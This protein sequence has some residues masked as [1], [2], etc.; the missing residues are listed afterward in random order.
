MMKQEI[1]K[2]IN[3]CIE[4]LNNGKDSSQEVE[5][6]DATVLAIIKKMGGLPYKG[7]GLGIG[8]FGYGDYRAS[9]EDM[10]GM[11]KDRKTITYALGWEDAILLLYDFGNYTEDGILQSAQGIIKDNIIFNHIIKHCITNLVIKNEV[12]EA[13]KFISNFRTTK[14][15]KEE[16]NH[17]DGY[18]II[19]KHFALNADVVNFFKYFK[20]SKPAINKS[21]VND[22]KEIL[23]NRFALKNGIEETMALCKH[24]NLGDKI[25]SKYLVCLCRTR[26]ISATQNYF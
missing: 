26:E 4:A 6:D 17:D 5:G 3:L 8:S 1:E 18:L 21:E 16:D 19:L 13:E 9:Q 22:A 14:I 11:F 25:S 7:T 20:P 10:Y 23:V 2:A 15:F 12:E 24:K